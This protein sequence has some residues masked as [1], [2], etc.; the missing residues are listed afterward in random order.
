M[1]ED[2]I[3][4]SDKIPNKGKGVVVI[5]SDSKIHYCFRC[6]CKNKSCLEWR[7]SITGFSLLIDVVK[8]K[9]Q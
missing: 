4:L 3:L 9:Y 2:F 8:W 1:E 6:S 7:C 5:D